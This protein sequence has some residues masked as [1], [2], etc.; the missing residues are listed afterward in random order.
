[1]FLVTNL[2]FKRS[3]KIIFNNVGLS[4]SPNKLIQIRGRNGIGKTTLIKVL[5]N[6]MPADEGD[7]FWNGKNILKNNDI[8]YKNLTLIMDTNS[9]KLDMTVLE[10]INY[11]K[12]IFSS[13]INIETINKILNVLSLS[14][15]KNVM[16]NNLSAGE[17][18]RLEI[19]RLIIERKQ[20]WILDEPYL[21]LDD[22]GIQTLDQTLKNHIQ[23]GGM[24]IFSSH[25]QPEIPGIE[26]LELEN[27]ATN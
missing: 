26:T 2:I 13:E 7:I 9:S 8:F 23:N 19:T 15:Y 1:M 24:A 10:N 20:L 6:I 14:N 22:T 4:L 12:N 17:K 27:Y 18:R 21:N 3:E 25:Y 11:W 16:V 5:A